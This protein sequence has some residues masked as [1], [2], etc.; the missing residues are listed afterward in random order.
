[1]ASNHGRAT[2]IVTA[3]LLALGLAAANVFFLARMLAGSAVAG[4]PVLEALADAY[5]QRPDAFLYLAVSPVVVGVLIALVAAIAGAAAPVAAQEEEPKA[6]AA[7]PHAS[8]LRLLALL[9]QEGRLI[10]FLEESIESYTD[11]Q[12]GAAVR[13]IH[14][15][16]RKALRERLHLERIR[17]E[18]DGATVEIGPGFDA[19]EI[20]LT[21]NVHGKPPFRGT[22]QHGG[23]RAAEIKFPDPLAAADATILA[24]AEVEV[25]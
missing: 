25:Q 8:A 20:R 17:S 10:D 11:A 2:V 1:M 22:L 13:A 18:E 16:C 3:L 24:P 23:W 14:S 5:A 21:G 6:P 12:V 7:S 15:G 4:L 19:A 9:Q